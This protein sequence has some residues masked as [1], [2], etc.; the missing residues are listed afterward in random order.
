MGYPCSVTMGILV[1]LIFATELD[2]FCLL[3]QIPFLSQRTCSET[4][5]ALSVQ[6][7]KAVCSPNSI[8]TLVNDFYIYFTDRIKL[9]FSP[10]VVTARMYIASLA[11]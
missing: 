1:L 10:T 4:T 6:V 11:D 2:E 5:K 3:Y 8:H 7:A 9:A